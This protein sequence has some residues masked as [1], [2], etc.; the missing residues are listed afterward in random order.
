MLL[1]LLLLVAVQLLPLMRMLLLPT[2][3]LPSLQE[4]RP[5]AAHVRSA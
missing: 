5:V 2:P 4:G 3:D 1:L